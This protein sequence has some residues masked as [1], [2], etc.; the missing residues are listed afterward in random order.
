MKDFSIDEFEKAGNIAHR[1]IQNESCSE[2]T[3][4]KISL[5][6]LREHDSLLKCKDDGNPMERLGKVSLTGNAKSHY[7][8]V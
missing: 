3:H 5:R 2:W 4:P 7:R 1:L 8:V 6:P